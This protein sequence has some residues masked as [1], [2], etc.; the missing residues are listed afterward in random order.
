MSGPTSTTTEAAI[1]LLKDTPYFHDS[2]DSLLQDLAVKSKFGFVP[3][4]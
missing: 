1:Q 2:S 3:A 4:C